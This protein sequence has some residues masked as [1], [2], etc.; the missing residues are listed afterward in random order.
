MY[1]SFIADAKNAHKALHEKL[2]NMFLRI[3]QLKDTT[4]KWLEY[5]VEYDE[6]MKLRDEKRK[7]FDHYDE[8]MGNLYEER[9]KII[10]KEIYLMKK[11]E[12]Y[13]RNI[14]KYQE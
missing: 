9:Q 14:K 5:I 3:D 8:K 2:T 13:M 6:K 1:S 11:E 10:A 4:D 12:K 7:T